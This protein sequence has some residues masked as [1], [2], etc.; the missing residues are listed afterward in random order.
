MNFI[1]ITEEWYLW[2]KALHVISVIAWMAGML[3]LPRIF[4][5]HAK[6]KIGATQSETFKIMERRLLK[7][8]MLPAMISTWFFGLILAFSPGGVDW[9]E[10]WAWGKGFLVILL[11]AFH[12]F[13]SNCQKKFAKDENLYSPIFYRIINEVPTII[14][15]GIIILV[16]VKPF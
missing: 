11:T 10:G 9:T 4:V 12:G 16:I 13:F 14:L 15:V 8:I 6:S 2:I 5:Y 1:V 7:G 3:Y